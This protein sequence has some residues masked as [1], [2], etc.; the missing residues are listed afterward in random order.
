MPRSAMT[1]RSTANF[2]ESLF[3]ELDR[4]SVRYCVLHSYE[5]LPHELRSDLDMAIDP[6]DTPKLNVVFQA[7]LERGYT[8]LQKITYAAGRGGSH[9]FIFGWLETGSFRT[10]AIDFTG[11]HREGGAILMR[12]EDLVRGRDRRNGFWIP[13]PSVEF[14]YLIGKKLMKGEVGPRQTEA[15]AA[16]VRRIG[17]S[18]AEESASHLVGA[19]W[20][21]SLVDAC[22]NGSLEAQI[23][24][25]R[26]RA[27]HE[28]WKRRPFDKVRYM[29]TEC[30]RWIDRVLHP[31]G[32]VVAVFGPDGAGKSSLIEALTERV[33]GCF[34]QRRTFHWRPHLLFN[35]KSIQDVTRPHDQ[36]LLSPVNSAMHVMA[37]ALDFVL[38]YLVTVFP[39][40]IRSGLAL[41][42]RYFDDVLV[43]PKRYR[44][45]GPEWLPAALRR[46][47]PKPDLLLVLEAPVDVIRGR[48][49]ELPP[50]EVA[51]QTRAYRNLA[52]Q[53]KSARL[54]NASGSPTE[55]AEAA[56]RAVSEFLVA[57]FNQDVGNQP[58]TTSAAG[59]VYDAAAWMSA[60][61]PV[62]NGE[63]KK[64]VFAVV[65]SK[66]N[67]R[68]I[69]PL[70][71]GPAYL[72]ALN[73][74]APYST[75]G[76][77]LK[78][79]LSLG[80]R[81][82]ES[83][84]PG[85]VVSLLSDGNSPLE[86]LVAERLGEPNPVFGISFGTSGRHRKITVQAMGSS[87][88]ILGY[89]KI[90]MTTF[91]ESR[92]RHEANI[93]AEFGRHSSIAGH[94]P[95]L[96]FTG[97]W[98]D[99]YIMIQ[100]PLPGPGGPANLTAAHLRFLQKLRDER[101]VTCRGSAFIRRIEMEYET[102]Q[103]LLDSEWNTLAREM[104]RVARVKIDGDLL[105]CGIAH[106][107]FAPWNTRMSNGEVG[108]FDWEC[109]SWEE[110]VWWD[111]FH[112]ETQSRI[113]L[114]SR[115]SARALPDD[116]YVCRTTYLLYLLLSTCRIL[117]DEPA[118]CSGI[119]WRKRRLINE[120]SAGG[121]PEINEYC[122]MKGISEA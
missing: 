106:G 18:A 111:I 61:G 74:L 39:L 5:G 66:A 12:G 50:E 81:I 108:V 80:L 35:R 7:L 119:A 46:L 32:L 113:L 89:I 41:F 24:C 83:L 78:K 8:P 112:F 109:M 21:A 72:S 67:P 1:C 3:E 2:L 65:P 19:S 92:V 28:F 99:R 104:L 91:G 55:V 36:S 79:V 51:A 57:R 75:R 13:D 48:K 29:A 45:G 97:E 14:Q 101:P 49:Q 17:R 59:H 10:A 93:L 87:G 63:H 11:E 44:Y 103:D 20:K 60:P 122:A 117:Q 9:Y 25:F 90:P 98:Q 77:L 42:D 56:A 96:I 37:H 23:R 31:T 84:W 43:D 33:G 118:E 40:R 116:D 6:A 114:N 16:L 82:P 26:R 88:E 102:V 121:P 38:G 110:P 30:P 76:R 53:S 70:H 100:A 85:E 86:K 22:L 34:R 71:Q 4:H 68:W 69:I 95:R 115:P 73:M 94:I 107:D 105:P 52:R 120:L 54:I 58:Q 15:L 62:P 27:R 47:I 64:R